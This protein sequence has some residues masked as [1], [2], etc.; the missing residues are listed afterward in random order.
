MFDAVRPVLADA[1]LGARVT[2]AA[3]PDGLV[4]L[5]DDAA[6]GDVASSVT[7]LLL[8]ALL[9][10][11]PWSEFEPG[12]I[13][14]ATLAGWARPPAPSRAAGDPRGRWLWVAVLVLLAVETGVRRRVA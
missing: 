9:Q 10:P 3:D 4:V 12:V 5:V 14:P 6:G 13:A 7:A 1:T 2:A 11:L 8:G